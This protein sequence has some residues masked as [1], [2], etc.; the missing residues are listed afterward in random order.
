MSFYGALITWLVTMI[1]VDS[2]LFRPLREWVRERRDR[3]DKKFSRSYRAWN[4]LSYLVGCRLCAGV[5]IGFGAALVLPGPTGIFLL[6]G[7]IYK[8]GAHLLLI[9][10]HVAEAYVARA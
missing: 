6:D 5:W 3:A 4:K 9:G 8:A 2:E 10:Q 7:L 1:V